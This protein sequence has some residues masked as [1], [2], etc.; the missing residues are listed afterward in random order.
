MLAYWFARK[1]VDKK[2]FIQYLFCSLRVCSITDQI[3]P[4][5][6]GS[7]FL[8]HAK[9]TGALY[10]HRV[11]FTKDGRITIVRSEQMTEYNFQTRQRMGSKNLNGPIFF[12]SSPNHLAFILDRKVAIYLNF[13]WVPK[14]GPLQ[15]AIISTIQKP[16][17][18]GFRIPTVFSI[19][20]W[21]PWRISRGCW[22]VNTVLKSKWPFI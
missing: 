15:T 2:I 4:L 19:I 22:L 3:I 18:S 12:T 16:D 11:I 7:V 10:K 8:E 21:I 6:S 17:M 13:E 5:Q 1:S 14:S 9:L 20:F